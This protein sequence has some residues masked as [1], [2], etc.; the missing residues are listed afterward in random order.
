[1]IIPHNKFNSLKQLDRI[2]FR[3]KQDRI[4][5]LFRYAGSLTSF[6]FWTYVLFL[7]GACLLTSSL[8]GYQAAQLVF[9]K[10][11]NYSV[12]VGIILVIS[13]IYDIYN[14]ILRNKVL[15]ALNEEYFKVEVKNVKRRR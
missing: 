8:F 5:K 9:I 12:L 6:L 13:L 11:M 14:L 2:E 3:Q 4:N 10:I 15:N 1:M 7:T